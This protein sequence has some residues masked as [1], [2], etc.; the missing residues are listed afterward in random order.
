M[1]TLIRCRFLV[2]FE[3]EKGLNQ[4]FNNTHLAF[5]LQP[6]L[7]FHL[8]EF[9]PL[10]DLFELGIVFYYLKVVPPILCESAIFQDGDALTL[11][12]DKH[13]AGKIVRYA[14]FQ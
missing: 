4:I 14:L 7:G 2:L 13:L 12:I 8:K 1:L 6:I 3:A 10:E 5:V 9:H 11:L